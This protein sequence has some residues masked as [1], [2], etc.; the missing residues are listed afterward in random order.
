M[1]DAPRQS[2]R[3]SAPTPLAPEGRVAASLVVQGLSH[4]Y[5]GGERPALDEVSF[6]L[7]PGT[8]L[9]LL[10]PNGAG[11]STLMRIVCGYLPVQTGGRARVEVAGLDVRTHSLGV[12]ERVGYMPEQVPLYAELRA[13]EHLQFRAKIKQVPWRQRR[14]EIA[15]V[16]ELTGIDH[17][18]DRPIFEL[19][20]GYRQRVGLADAL[21][22]SPPLL[23]LDEPTVG[24]D[25]NQVLEIRAMLRDVG[26]AQTLVLSS[27]ILAEVEALC[28]R[29]VIL[30]EGRVAADE[31]LTEALAAMHVE[32]AWEA[33]VQTAEAIVADAFDALDV[34][35][36]ARR[37]ELSRA[38]E[39]TAARIHLPR[40]DGAP[41]DEG[42]L[43]AIG[44]ASVQ[45][46]VTLHLLR[47][48]RT[49][50]EERF[51]EVTGAA[52]SPEPSQEA[53]GA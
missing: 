11:K 50:L 21:L 12:R 27:H 47:P 9:G 17:V 34:G 48:G 41:D 38:G 23:V 39:R 7:E 2:G 49:R 26:G 19:S 1:I 16:A 8:R 33:D 37:V 15:R 44:R 10:G 42:L 4:R 31:P 24:L 36:E 29:V 3:S 32:A 30:S 28:D 18:L 25:P 6:S 51:A 14:A 52:R 22:G 35:P 20:R 53:R 5:P 45:R 46:G 40:S 13:R 43:E